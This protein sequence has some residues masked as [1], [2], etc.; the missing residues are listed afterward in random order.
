MYET[1]KAPKCKIVESELYQADVKAF[2]TK[3]GFLTNLSTTMYAMLPMFE[4]GSKEHK[5]LIRRLKQCRKEQGSIIDA[6]KG[7]DIK[8]IPEHW[9]KG[10]K[11]SDDMTEEEKER[12][13]FNNSILID[14]RPQ[15]MQY[16][17]SNYGKEYKQYY[18][19]YDLLAQARFRMFMDELISLDNANLD[20]EKKNF[21]EEFKKYNPLLDTCCETNNISK[22]MQK[23]IKEIKFNNKSLWCKEMVEPMKKQDV[24]IWDDSKS[25]TIVFL[26]DKYKSGRRNFGNIKNDDGNRLQTI[27]QY[28][29]SILNESLMISSDLG[30]LAYYAIARC[31]ISL[32][33]DNKDFVWSVFGEGVINNLIDNLGTNIVEVPF[34][35]E[36]GDIEY[37]GKRYKRKEVNI[38][39]EEYYGIL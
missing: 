4:E 15:F 17:Y 22:Y 10:R 30:E 32:K 6:T 3:V 29:K 19:D 36:S 38:I 14:K 39:P 1:R 33:G 31:Y 13:R 2:N 11:I 9:T 35:D 34:L 27:E 12:I 18:T 7:L 24:S 25:D 20:S 21:V 23:K 37:L 16:L 8:P 26:H 28:C 5:E